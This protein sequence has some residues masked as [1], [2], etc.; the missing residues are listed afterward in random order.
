[1][2]L[3]GPVRV[4]VHIPRHDEF[5]L[6]STSTSTTRTGSGPLLDN[7]IPAGP[8]PRE[9]VDRL[10]DILASEVATGYLPGLVSLVA[11]G[12]E[13]HIDAIGTP[14]FRDDT[15]LSRHAIFRIASLTKPIV[16]VAA[17][18]LVEEGVLE[19]A[20]PIEQ[21]VPELASPRVL[22][23]LDA[24]LDDTA[25]VRRPILLEDLL[26]YRLGFGS[27]MAPPGT[28]PIQRA[29]AELGLQSIGGPPWPPGPHDDDGWI[30][31]LG[32][33]PLMYQPG[34]RWLYNTSG[35]VLGILVARAC[36]GSLESALRARVFEPLGMTD[37]GFSVPP[38]KQDRLPTLYL[39][40]PETGVLS[41][42]DQAPAS[43]WSTPPAFADGSG[44]L[45]STID[46][47]W[48]FVSMVLAGGA[49]NGRRVLSPESVALMTSDHLTPAQRDG[50]AVFLGSHGSWGFGLSVP[51]NGSA[52]E[53]FPC[54]TGWDG[55]TGTT[56]RSDIRRGVTAMLFTQRHATSPVPS[57]LMERFWGAVNA[58]TR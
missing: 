6:C 12:D 52:D 31:T 13:V 38:E 21:L 33:L 18:S 51:A 37:T 30:A 10:H 25:P 27:V 36:G 14:S 3:R 29:E 19:L 9:G 40:D 41:V 2:E 26:S 58:A 56:W 4:G 46:D 54:G 48:S 17:L 32:T 57:P 8:L 44:W 16:A 15:P 45:V 43:W 22:R 34:E 28:Y 5:V 55:G 11:R 49:G 39:P 24:E 47:Y 7:E 53:P 42:F 50:N 23:S 1:V 35:Q 20:Q